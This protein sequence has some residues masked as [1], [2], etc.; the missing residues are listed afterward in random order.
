MSQVNEYAAALG[1]N[2]LVVIRGELKKWPGSARLVW[3]WKDE[4]F[5]VQWAEWLDRTQTRRA[6][7]RLE[8]ANLLFPVL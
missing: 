1:K 2:E 3:G 4:L 7:R 5:G 8:K 6:F